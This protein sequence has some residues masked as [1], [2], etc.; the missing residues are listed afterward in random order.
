MTPLELLLALTVV[1]IWGTNF[2]VIKIG[3][4]DFP[5]LLFA[6]LRFGFAALPW[7]LFIRR[8]AVAWRYLAAFGLFLGVGQ[9]G[10]LFIAM[11]GDITPGLASLLIQVQ[12]FFTIGLSL[13]L[14]AEHVHAR[15]LVGLALAIAGVV[16]IG[17]NV[18]AATTPKGLALVLLAALGWSG[19]NITVK[20]ANKAHGKFDVL[21]FMVWSSL[22]AVPPLGALAS[23]GWGAWAAV[24]W[25]SLGNTLFGYGVWNWLL[26]RHSAAAFTPTSLLVPVFGM[27]ASSLVLDEPLHGWKLAA[28]GLIVAGLAVNMFGGKL[29]RAARPG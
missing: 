20:Y 7:L 22:F 29:A 3:L 26:A 1:F 28:A 19:A 13:W 5:P 16:V 15:N 10:S 23:A 21:G 12:V 18:D 25:Q 2:V 4:G 17:L 14:F 11:R 24:L 6:A 27:A 9:F 8:P